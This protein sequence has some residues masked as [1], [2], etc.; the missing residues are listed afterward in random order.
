DELAEIEHEL[1]HAGA[2]PVA[3]EG[4]FAGP[5]DAGEAQPAGASSFLLHAVGASFVRFLLDRFGRARFFAFT[6]RLLAPAAA[7]RGVDQGGL[8]AEVFGAPARDAA[9]EWWSRV[10]SDRGTGATEMGDATTL[11]ARA[12]ADIRAVA[13]AQ[14]RGE[15][16]APAA[17][18]A[19]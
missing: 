3:V 14:Q 4:F 10:R 15:S 8:F 6:E 18:R 12:R 11:C 1:A 17:R 5:R 16:D 7:L 2:P 9:A 19:V 13:A